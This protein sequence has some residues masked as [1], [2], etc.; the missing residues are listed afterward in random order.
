MNLRA[1][2]ARRQPAP[3]VDVEEVARAAAMRVAAEMLSGPA[4]SLSQLVERRDLTTPTPYAMNDPLRWRSYTD[5]RMRP[6]KI[7]TVDTLRTLAQSYDVLAACIAHL[8]DQ[9]IKTD[10]KIG[11][12]NDKDKSPATAAQIAEAQAFFDVFGGLGGNGTTRLEFEGRWLDDLIIVGA[13][14]LF[15]EYQTVGSTAD[16]APD[17]VIAIDASTIRPLITQFGFDPDD[18][19]DAYAQVVMGREV[20]R[21]KRRDLMYQGLPIFAQ[22]YTPYFLSAVELLILIV[23]TALKSDEWNR[24]WLTDGNV[25]DMMVQVPTEWTPDQI[26]E[27]A[28]Y[29]DALLSGS[30]KDR[31]KA[32]VVPAG[33]HG[34]QQSRK[35]ADFQQFDWWLR[36]RTCSMMGVS[37]VSIGYSS[38]TYKSAEE[39]AMQ[40][41]TDN[42]VAQ[43]LIFRRTVYNEICRRKGWD[44]IKVSDHEPD[45]EEASKRAERHQVEIQS[46]QRTPNECRVEDGLDTLPDDGADMLLVPS[47]LVPLSRVAA[48]PEPQPEPVTDGA[49]LGAPEPVQRM[50]ELRQWERKAVNRLRQGKAAAC[51]FTAQNIPADVVEEVS[52]NLEDCASVSEV[53]RVFQL[54]R[55][56]TMADGSA[57]KVPDIGTV[58]PWT[59]EEIEQMTGD[60]GPDDVAQALDERTPPMQALLTA[61]DGGKEDAKPA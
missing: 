48:E 52:W 35:D 42:R 56:E 37:P 47:T 5:P 57:P 59:D 38:Q 25:P 22:T 40:G 61:K 19:A 30:A 2:F 58:Q 36:D 39:G 24:T 29:F 51:P 41:T 14:A 10:L 23:M 4:E 17:R 50:E 13:S 6:Y 60:L 46:G 3:T 26:R 31:H 55:S 7:V 44:A 8:K 12:K 28:A 11:P 53:R 32:K 18:N 27:Y 34:S 54:A 20:A 21:F 43:L 49:K 45:S 15:M 16:G 33:V 9:V 1:L